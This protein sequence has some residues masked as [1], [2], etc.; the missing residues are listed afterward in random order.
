MSI[1][2]IAI[3]FLKEFPGKKLISDSNGHGLKYFFKAM[4]IE[5][6]DKSTLYDKDEI[7]TIKHAHELYGADLIPSLVK[8][9]LVIEK[10]VLSDPN[11]YYCCR[12]EI[13]HHLIELFESRKYEESKLEP[14][15]W[16]VLKPFHYEQYQEFIVKNSLDKKMSVEVFCQAQCALH[17]FFE[18]L[19]LFGLR[20]WSESAF[21]DANEKDWYELSKE[22]LA[23]RFNANCTLLS[24][25]SDA[26]SNG[27]NGKLTT[28]LLE[29]YQIEE[30]VRLKEYLE[31]PKGA[32]APKSMYPTQEKVE[33][34]WDKLYDFAYDMKCIQ[35]ENI[36]ACL[37]GDKEAESVTRLDN[38]L[39]KACE[40][41]LGT[42]AEDFKIAAEKSIEKSSKP[43]G[44]TINVEEENERFRSIINL[45]IWQLYGKYD[46]NF[47]KLHSLESQRLINFMI[48][49]D[50]VAA[51]DTRK[52]VMNEIHPDEPEE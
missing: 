30:Q 6:L 40:K 27:R 8:L 37:I 20:K 24:A 49:I 3:K 11:P 41:H 17:G 1:F 47:D 39:F 45:Q 28:K 35:N 44:E 23:Y 5:R 10:R 16:Q 25:M 46:R 26:L 18:K 14:R 33:L 51:E 21:A 19:V 22:Y 34:N 12:K 42:K 15:L 29:E 43:V 36:L 4:S 38:L 48:G 50:N 7:Q 2:N 31:L 32:N 9:S 52:K 13:L